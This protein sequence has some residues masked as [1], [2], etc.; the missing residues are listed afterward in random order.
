M[1]LRLACTQSF[2]SSG[3]GIDTDGGVNISSSAIITDREFH[4]KT[5]DRDCIICLSS[6]YVDFSIP[7]VSMG[8]RLVSN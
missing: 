2:S 1:G 7:Q 6:P 8:S 5:E 3:S 4:L